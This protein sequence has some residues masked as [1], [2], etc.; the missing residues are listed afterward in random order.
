MAKG[1]IPI[2]YDNLKYKWHDIYLLWEKVFGFYDNPI[3]QNIF[4]IYH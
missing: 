3:N 4:L 1:K 2:D